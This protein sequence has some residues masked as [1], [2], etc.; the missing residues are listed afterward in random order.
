VEQVQAQLSASERKVGEDKICSSGR[1]LGRRSWSLRWS[2]GR[3][4]SNAAFWAVT[5]PHRL[6]SLPYKGCYYPAC[7]EVPRQHSAARI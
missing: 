3:L 4:E 6:A 2:V 7:N 1:L 5:A